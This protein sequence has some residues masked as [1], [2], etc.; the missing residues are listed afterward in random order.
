VTQAWAASTTYLVGNQVVLGGNIYVCDTDGV[1]ASSG[2][3]TGTGTNIVDGTTRWDYVSAVGTN[4][5]GASL[6]DQQAGITCDPANFMFATVW[7]NR[8][9]FVEEGTARAWYMPVGQLYGTATSINFGVRFKGGGHL[10]GLYSWSYDGGSGMDTLLVAISSAGDVAIYQGTDPSSASTFGLKGVWSVGGVPAGRRVATDYGGELLVL[11]SLGVVPL[12]KLVV[13]GATEAAGLYATAKIS[14]LF[15]RLMQSR[16]N[17][18]GWAVHIHPTDNALMV[19][20]P[21]ASGGP[22]EP[23]V[24][25]MGTKGWTQYRDLPIISGETWGGE[26]YFGTDEGTVCWNT[27]YIDAVTLADPNV[28]SE[29][30]WSVLT[31][32][33]DLGN[34][35]QKRLHMIQPKILSSSSAPTVQTTARFNYNFTEPANPSPNPAGLADAWDAG[36]WDAAIWGGEFSPYMPIQ[37]AAG[38]GRD[39][40]VA[41]RGR[42][43]SKTTLVALTVFFEQGGVL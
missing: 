43:T 28:Y 36:V 16:R 37:G 8:L 24:M 13:G 26:F 22:G 4:T 2:G 31:A 29:I 11:S 21:D 34:A 9:W 35:R 6:A 30:Q 7:K 15:S 3:P 19:L 38:M 1:S 23:L 25:A 18:D 41:V 5:I 10:V 12:S 17:L 42:A 39:V 40:A 33:R 20:V 32:F 27:D 14:N